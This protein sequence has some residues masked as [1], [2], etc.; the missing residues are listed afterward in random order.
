MAQRATFPTSLL[1]EWVLVPSTVASGKSEMSAQSHLQ[2]LIRL[3]RGTES[4]FFQDSRNMTSSARL[5]GQ[6][7]TS[8]RST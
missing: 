6:L 8:E 7:T 5:P 2:I 3:V 4:T 1:V